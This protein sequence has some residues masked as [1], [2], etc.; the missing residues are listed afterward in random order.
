MKEEEIEEI[1]EFEIGEKK[2]KKREKEIWVKEIPDIKDYKNDTNYYMDEKDIR[3]EIKKY[4]EMLENLPN[5]KEKE[6]ILGKVTFAIFTLSSFEEMKKDPGYQHCAKCG[7][8]FK[9][10]YQIDHRENNSEE[11]F[12]LCE[13]CYQ[14]IK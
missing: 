5:G 11:Y 3:R 4:T 9:V 1:P 6:K 14:E 10:D 8:W 12:I 2:F 13:K 7:K